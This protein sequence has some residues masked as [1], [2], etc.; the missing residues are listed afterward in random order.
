VAGVLSGWQYDAGPL[1]LHPGDLGWHSLRGAAKTA[2]SLQAWS[3]RG[4]ILALQWSH[5]V[6]EDLGIRSV[7]AQRLNLQ[8]HGDFTA[9][10]N[11]YSDR[12]AGFDEQS[13]A[14]AL[15]L[16]T[17]AA[18]V[19]GE[20]LAEERAE[21]LRRALESNREMGVAM[22]TLMNAHHLTREQ[23][24]GVLRVASQS[25]NRRL[26]AIAGRRRGH[27]HL[28][29][30]PQSASLLNPH[31]PGGAGRCHAPFLCALPDKS[32]CLSCVSLAAPG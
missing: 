18:H 27:R 9:G 23:A 26:A 17:H 28:G 24:F 10:V 15:I 30:P 21:Q 1:H 6:G 8:D 14:M 31:S 29:H 32:G 19:V 16:A 7:V 11:V 20:N 25:S 22:A 2:V 4:E 3:R 12:A 5:R 13:V